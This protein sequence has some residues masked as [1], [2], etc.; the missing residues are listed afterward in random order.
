MTEELRLSSLIPPSFRAVHEDLREFRHRE[1]W[2]KGGRGSGKSTFLSLEILLGMLRDP[3]ANAVVYRR[4]GATLR[5]S[6]YEQMRWAVERLGLNGRAA[7]RKAP[8]EIALSGA[9]GEQRIL[10]RGADDPAKSKSIKLARG[11]FAYL[12]FEELAEFPDMDAIRQIQA[13]VI[14]GRGDAVTLCSYNPP[15]SFSSWVNE[16]AL[17]ARPD[18]LVHASTYLDLPG[19]WLGESFLAAAEELRRADPGAYRHMYLGEVTGLGGQV[20]ENVALRTVTDEELRAFSDIRLGLDWGWYPDPMH[21]VRCAWEP[22]RRRLT[23]FDELRALRM[24]NRTLARTLIETG[25]IQPGEEV[26][27]DS[28]EQKSIADMRAYGVRCVAAAKGPGSVRAGIKWLQSLDEIVIDPTRCPH[29]ARE[30]T[31]YEYERD[32]YGTPVDQLPDR[33]NHAIDAVRYA[34]NR[35]WRRAGE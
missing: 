10:F 7:F 27:A 16:E 26:V 12:W 5:E 34:M 9:H 30:F 24:D 18:R 8:L 32:R 13:S 14:R 29:A 23:V 17:S 4:V 22:A 31:R 1:V 21:F 15:K 25:R 20:F 35:V 3:E 2:L 33:D 11:R 28:A 19:D 6:V